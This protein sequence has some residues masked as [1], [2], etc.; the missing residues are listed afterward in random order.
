MTKLKAY[1]D[2]AHEGNS[3]EYHTG[4]F[5]IEKDC[6]SPAGTLWS[7]LWCFKHNVERIRRIDLAL[8]Q[9]EKDYGLK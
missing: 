3:P 5:C 4:K 7:P 1:E 6:V 8:E 2:P 9:L